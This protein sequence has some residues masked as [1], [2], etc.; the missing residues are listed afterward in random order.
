MSSTVVVDAYEPEEPVKFSSPLARRFVQLVSGPDMTGRSKPDRS[1][2]V[3]SSGQCPVSPP[4]FRY[5]A[6]S[7]RWYWTICSAC[8]RCGTETGVNGVF[9]G[10]AA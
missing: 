5:P 2:P 8:T 10:C 1:A 6:A 7:M 9:R 4:S 3:P